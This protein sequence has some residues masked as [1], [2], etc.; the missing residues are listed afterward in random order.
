[1]T[2]DEQIGEFWEF[3]KMLQLRCAAYR[4]ENEVGEFKWFALLEIIY[5]LRMVALEIPLYESYNV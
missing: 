4:L 5:D 1:M 3:Q 2:F